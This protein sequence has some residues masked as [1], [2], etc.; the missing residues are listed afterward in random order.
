MK[1]GQPKRKTSK[2]KEPFKNLF[3]NP[4]EIT[5]KPTNEIINVQLDIGHFMEVLD[6]VLWPVRAQ[7]E[8]NRR[9]SRLKQVY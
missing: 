1:S 8:D 6:I 7:K 3:E 5:D 2:G 4:P 9:E